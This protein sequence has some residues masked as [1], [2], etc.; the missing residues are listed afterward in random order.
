VAKK[1]KKWVMKEGAAGER[2]KDGQEGEVRRWS[3][4]GSAVL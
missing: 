4:A 2:R 3:K 1:G